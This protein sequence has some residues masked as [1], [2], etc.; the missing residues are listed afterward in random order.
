VQLYTLR[1]SLLSS[2]AMY[3][4]LF[5]PPE[6]V[7]ELLRGFV[8][9]AWA[10]Q[11]DVAAFE[12]VSASYVSDGGQQRHSDVVWRVRIGEQWVYLYLLLELQAKP[13]PWM[14]LRMQVYSGLLCQ[15]LV[16][17]HQLT[18]D[19][20]LPPLLP[21]VLYHGKGHWNASMDLAGLMLPVP[22]GLAQFQPQQRYLLVE[23]SS[24][25]L[26]GQ[27][28]LVTALYDLTKV[29]S[30][31]ALRRV[32]RCVIARLRD[33]DMRPVRESIEAWILQSLQRANVRSNLNWKPDLE[34][35][36]AM[37]SF[38]SDNVDEMATHSL[39]KM[40][41]RMALKEGL[42]KGRQEGMLEGARQGLLE[43]VKQ[44]VPAGPQQVRQE[45][46]IE[47]LAEGLHQGLQQGL[48]RGRE[49]GL[50]EGELLAYRELVRMIAQQRKIDLPEAIDL[51]IDR[52]DIHKLHYW[53]LALA[54]GV[55]PWAKR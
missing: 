3:K 50:Q 37:L 33:D 30:D 39:I 7:R 31:S 15:D 48:Q 12:R 41:S 32:L 55:K 27:N 13:D 49:E 25:V 9:Q 14:A 17:Q 10:Q 24:D 2:D 52:A 40:Y 6:L 21:I 22:D 28:N 26:S 36:K 44:S 23:R 53:F 51:E 19:G 4:Q 35:V 29:R 46:L 34:E 45:S 42:E 18:A 20:R 8:P 16:R 54:D 47:G 11:L 1:M 5:S 38:E 43:G